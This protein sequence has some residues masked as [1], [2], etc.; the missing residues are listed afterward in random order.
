MVAV[1]KGW[2]LGKVRGGKQERESKVRTLPGTGHTPAPCRQVNKNDND[3][4]R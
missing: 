1:G 3:R 4:L 2:G